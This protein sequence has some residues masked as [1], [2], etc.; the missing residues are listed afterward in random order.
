MSGT[1]FRTNIHSRAVNTFPPKSDVAEVL[2]ML[3]EQRVP[4]ELVISLP[5]NGGVSGVVFRGK[6]KVNTEAAVSRLFGTGT[7]ATAKNVDRKGDNA[8]NSESADHS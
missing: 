4:G 1:E 8:D 3:R 6:E 5:G 7:S 2:E